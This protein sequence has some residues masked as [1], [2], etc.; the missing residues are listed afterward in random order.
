[1][2]LYKIA[3]LFK[4]KP[5]G[6]IKLNHEYSLV[7]IESNYAIKRMSRGD[8]LDIQ[9]SYMDH[10]RFEK[11]QNKCV[12]ND[13]EIALDRAVLFNI[14][15]KEKKTEIL[16]DIN[17]KPFKLIEKNN[18]TDETNIFKLTDEEKNEFTEKLYMKLNK[19]VSI[20]EFKYGY[21]VKFSNGEYLDLQNCIYKWRINCS[22]FKKWCTSK[23]LH[24]IR[25]H[26]KKYDKEILL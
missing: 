10:Y 16:D 6:C 26:I 12:T 8:Y 5:K 3:N 19:G 11:V 13:I 7:K 1:M 15:T 25:N 22:D 2:I 21:A 14:I 17:P 20:V 24:K 18:T 23:D 9:C 4:K